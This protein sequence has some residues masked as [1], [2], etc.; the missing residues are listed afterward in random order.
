MSQVSQRRNRRI[1]LLTS[2]LYLLSA[3]LL[4]A[5]ESI[6]VKALRRPAFAGSLTTIEV[7]INGISLGVFGNG[8]SQTLAFNHAKLGKN[9]VRLEQHSVFGTYPFYSNGQIKTSDKRYFALRQAGATVTILFGE[10][11]SDYFT[12]NYFTVSQEVPED[13]DRPKVLKV[14]LDPQLKAV[15]I[16]KSPSIRLARGTEKTV[17]D[18]LTVKHEVKITKHWKVEA[19]LRSQFL[20]GLAFFDAQVRGEIES[21]THND[22]SV[23]S[24]RTRSVVVRGDAS[25]AH[26]RVVW[27][28]YYRT[29][30]ATVRICD[31]TTLVPFEFREDFDLLTEDA[32]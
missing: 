26:I 15:V 1:R 29:G 7:Y 24:S 18:T 32:Q 14:A 3:A 9:E 19:A 22:Y 20:V 31:R 27:V 30:I 6:V 25:Q 23:E 16:K 17:Q 11:D 2:C 12:K 21:I 10:N 28:E 8:V 5:D 13:W 4:G